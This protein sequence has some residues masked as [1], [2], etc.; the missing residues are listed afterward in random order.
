MYVLIDKARM[1]FCFRHTSVNTVL[2][3][4]HI[5]L[6]ENAAHAI[7]EDDASET[8]WGGL[9]TFEMRVLYN[10]TVDCP[11]D[12]SISRATLEKALSDIVRKLPIA[13]VDEGEV[14]A[15]ANTISE[16]DLDSYRYVK[17]SKK[18]RIRPDEQSLPILK[19]G[20]VIIRQPKVEPTEPVRQPSKP[21][22]AGGVKQHIRN[23][24]AEASKHT[25]EALTDDGKF[26]IASIKTALSDLKNAKYAGGEILLTARMKIDGVD[27]YVKE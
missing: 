10:N 24:F 17:G 14:A 13:D 27:H 22:I 8:G 5:E 25:M 18:P 7:Q 1:C 15:Q 26:S 20:A 19:A 21:T 2:Q 9:L 4:A 6:G 16:D 11:V 23:M 3:L 12:A